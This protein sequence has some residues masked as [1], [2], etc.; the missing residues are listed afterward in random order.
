[1]DARGVQ[2]LLEKTLGLAETADHVGSRN[3][4]MMQ[5]EPRLSEAAKAKLA[6]L[7]AEHAQR[8]VKLY[9]ALGLGICDVVQ[10]ELEDEPARAALESFRASLQALDERADSALR[11][12]G[13]RTP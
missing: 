2:R 5:R 4:E 13:N 9:A 11:D 8:L 10:E 1:M 6:P 12:L 7:Y 3:V